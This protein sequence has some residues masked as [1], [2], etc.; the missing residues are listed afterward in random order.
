MLYI[1]LSIYEI[2]TKIA[3]INKYI[4][5]LP[6]FLKPTIKKNNPNMI[7]ENIGSRIHLKVKNNLYELY[8]E[9]VN[10]EK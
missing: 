3:P 9:I 6:L 10:G 7:I 2:V 1:T 4:S 5:Y 8:S